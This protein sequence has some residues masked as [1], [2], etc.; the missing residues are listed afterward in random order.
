[1]GFG[2]MAALRIS[3]DRYNAIHRHIQLT[4]KAQL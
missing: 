1:M 2:Y 4:N 3:T